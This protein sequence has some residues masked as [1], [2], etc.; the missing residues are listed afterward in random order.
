MF[1]IA[2][3]LP[4]WDKS[5]HWW[6]GGD[7]H[8][9]AG[10]CSG[11]QLGWSCSIQGDGWR[12]LC[13][14]WR[15]SVSFC[16]RFQ[17]VR[18]WTGLLKPE[19]PATGTGC[20]HFWLF[21]RC[22]L[23]AGDLWSLLRLGVEADAVVLLVVCHDAAH[24]DVECVG[25]ALLQ[26]LVASLVE[27]L[28]NV[29]GAGLLLVEDLGDDAVTLGA[30]RAADCA[31]AQVHQLRSDLRHL[32]KIGNLSIGTNQVAGLY[33]CS[34]FLGGLGQIAGGLD[35]VVQFLGLGGQ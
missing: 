11:G 14:R 20:G 10:S 7:S 16:N 2:Y 15:N 25:A 12:Q 24:E 26:K 3:L 28:G 32:T 9:S 19:M 5:G 22:L 30:D 8:D 35:L 34:H 29:F 6:R 17:A 4:V 27:V 21:A 31:D 33:S 18:V 1:A 13:L 23:H